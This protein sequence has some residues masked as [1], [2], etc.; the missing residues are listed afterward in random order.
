VFRIVSSKSTLT[1]ESNGLPSVQ[2]PMIV[3][4]SNDHDR[5]DHDFTIYHDRFFFDG[6]HT[7]DGGLREVDAVWSVEKR[8]DVR[9][10]G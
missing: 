9:C 6:V 7:K 8:V 4:Q 10:S 3:C 2:Q 5:S 1:K